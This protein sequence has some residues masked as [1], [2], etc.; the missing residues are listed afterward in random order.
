M[1]N[2]Y[3]NNNNSFAGNTQ[4]LYE[5]AAFKGITR[6]TAIG[7]KWMRAS[8]ANAVAV[9]VAVAVAVVAAV[10]AVVVAVVAVAVVEKVS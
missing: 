3:N 4:T 6:T 5:K 7:A 2:N 9:V 8:I 1:Y 10:V